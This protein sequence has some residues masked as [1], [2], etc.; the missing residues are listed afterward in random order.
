MEQREQAALATATG[1]LNAE[2]AEREAQAAAAARAELQKVA[3]DNAAQ[4]ERLKT[5]AA[6]REEEVRVQAKAEAD[7]A[8]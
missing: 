5:D 8:D 6:A 3:N 1:R 4:V 7:A 2:F